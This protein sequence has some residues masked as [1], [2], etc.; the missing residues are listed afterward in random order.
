VSGARPSIQAAPWHHACCLVLL[1]GAVASA[2]TAHATTS[3]SGYQLVDTIR[4]RGCEPSGQLAVDA[5]TRR[6]FVPCSTRLAVVD[7]EHGRQLGDITETRGVRGVALAPM[8]GRGFTSNGRANTVTIFGLQGLKTASDHPETGGKPAAIVYDPGSAR[9]FTM[10]VDSD[11]A[12]AITAADGSPAGTIPLGGRP[13]MAVTDGAG[14]V[15]VDLPD[16]NEIAVVDTRLLRVVRRWLVAPCRGSASLAIDPSHARLFLGCRN[17]TLA[18]MDT[19]SGR[20]VATLPI[21]HGVDVL[22]YDAGSSLV[23]A[24]S[25]N[26]TLGVVQQETPDAYRLVETIAMPPGVRAMELDP[27][28]HRLYLAVREPTDGGA[29]ERHRATAATGSLAILVYAR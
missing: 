22:R 7:L 15:Y 16:R 8:L 27:S 23:F 12:T 5:T 3:G 13:E 11:N 25:G 17:G 29:D 10:N 9:V 24:A 19:A 6:L 20:V 21:G 14:R 1:V 18:T 28:T 2:G 26:G 4:L